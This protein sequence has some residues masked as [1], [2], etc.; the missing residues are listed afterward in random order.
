[1]SQRTLAELKK[2]EDFFYSISKEKEGERVVTLYRGTDPREAKEV[3]DYAK[4]GQPYT[5]YGKWWSTDP[6][7]AK[8]YALEKQHFDAS[9]KWALL[10]REVK[11]SDLKSGELLPHL[12]VWD[13]FLGFRAKYRDEANEFH[14]NT[15][16]VY[17]ERQPKQKY[18][19]YIVF[20][21]GGKPIDAKTIQV[22]SVGEV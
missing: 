21:H 16:E 11:L 12:T 20:F 8:K 3:Q 18:S 10:A 22:L 1:M 13:E 4:R 5:M 17:I 15:Y 6:E 7:E 2:M 19:G 14:R 9:G